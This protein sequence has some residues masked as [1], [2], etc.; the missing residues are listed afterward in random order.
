MGS[1]SWTQLS[2]RKDFASLLTDTH[3]RHTSRQ[4]PRS[5]VCSFPLLSKCPQMRNYF[6]LSCSPHP[7]LDSSCLLLNYKG[8][9]Q[10]EAFIYL[11]TA[12]GWNRPSLSVFPRTG[13][14]ALVRSVASQRLGHD[15]AT[16][17]Q[18]SILCTWEA[19]TTTILSWHTLCSFS[20]DLEKRKLNGRAQV[21]LSWK[22]LLSSPCLTWANQLWFL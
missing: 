12:F 20:L 6:L 11:W 17:Q 10:C 7:H 9:V 13:K 18:R 5:P 16:E 14:P 22:S 21:I 8:C 19:P 2:Y 3:S 1:Q 4:G 15:W